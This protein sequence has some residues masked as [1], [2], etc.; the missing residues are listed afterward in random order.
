LTGHMDRTQVRISLGQAGSLIVSFEPSDTQVTDGADD[1]W[2]GTK[3]K[4]SFYQ[5][6]TEARRMRAAFVAT[7][8]TERRPSL[9]AFISNAVRLEV[10]RLERDHNGGRPWPAVETGEIPKGAPLRT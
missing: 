10:E 6:R 1:A 9:S 7:Q 3:V 2:D 8:A 5:A 4:T